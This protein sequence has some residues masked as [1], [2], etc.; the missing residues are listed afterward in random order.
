MANEMAEEM[1]EEGAMVL[2][3]DYSATAPLSLND[4]QLATRLEALFV[5]S[6]D[7]SDLIRASREAR[8]KLESTRCI[9]LFRR[10]LASQLS[11]VLQP[12]CRTLGLDV[13]AQSCHGAGL[14][15]LRS[16]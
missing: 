3:S 8:V 13:F 16:F 10:T 7:F 1:D 9:S 5:Q 14:D 4:D 2:V 15:V 6:S 12:I 11:I